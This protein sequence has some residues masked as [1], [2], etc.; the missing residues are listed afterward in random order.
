MEI[1]SRLVSTRKEL[2]QVH[3]LRKYGRPLSLQQ[4]LKQLDDVA[5]YQALWDVEVNKSEPLPVNVNRKVTFFKKKTKQPCKVVLKAPFHYK[6]GKHRL[7]LFQ[8]TLTLKYQYVNQFTIYAASVA[9]LLDN[10]EGVAAYAP[11][12]SASSVINRSTL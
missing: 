3:T 2:D 12:L 5:V 10:F 11:V 4:S 8:R 7:T 9:T 1:I 6:K